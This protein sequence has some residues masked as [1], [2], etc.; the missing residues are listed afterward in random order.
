MVIKHVPNALSLSRVIFLPLLFILI[1]AEQKNLFLPLYLILAS[2]DW[3]DGVVARRFNV[4]SSL[5]KSLDSIADL[6]FYISSAYF[7]NIIAPNAITDN[8][9]WLI[10][11]F[12]VLGLSFIVSA[13]RLGKPVLMHTHLLRLNAVLVVLTIAAAFMADVTIVVRIIC[14]I[15]YIAFAEEIAIFIMFPEA[16]PDDRTILKFLRRNLSE[17]IALE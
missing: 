7:L 12:S 9:V 16:D 13:V 15:Y 10:I 2:T 4:I 5:G 3:F 11:F 14:F 1:H 6:L 8:A 17:N